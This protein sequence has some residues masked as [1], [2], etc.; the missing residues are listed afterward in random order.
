L[1]AIST[2]SQISKLDAYSNK[3]HEMRQEIQTL[4]FSP[5]EAGLDIRLFGKGTKPVSSCPNSFVV[6]YTGSPNSLPHWIVSAKL[7]AFPPWSEV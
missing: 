6:W 5:A 7:G 1:E 2:D 4:D 3:K